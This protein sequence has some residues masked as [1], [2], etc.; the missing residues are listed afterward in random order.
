MWQPPS[1]LT[2]VKESNFRANTKGS[3]QRRGTTRRRHARRPSDYVCHA[4]DVIPEPLGSGFSS[5]ANAR[6]CS[7]GQARALSRISKPLHKGGR[8]GETNHVLCA[9]AIQ[10]ANQVGA[11][12][13]EGHR[14]QIPLSSQEIGL[15][16][17]ICYRSQI[18]RGMTW[19][20]RCISLRFCQKWT[21][22]EFDRDGPHCWLGPKERIIGCNPCFCTS[23]NESSG[24]LDTMMQQPSDLWVFGN[25]DSLCRRRKACKRALP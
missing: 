1:V 2:C 8:H 6:Q 9:N 22:A 18:S 24:G 3:F 7:L 11:A 19:L 14:D 20:D 17:S 15:R 4:I 10:A 21:L 5:T 13:T 23:H 16:P 25:R 12:R